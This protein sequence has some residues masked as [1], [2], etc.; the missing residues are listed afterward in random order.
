MSMHAL[1]RVSEIQLEGS[2]EA[3]EAILDESTGR[4]RCLCH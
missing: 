1:L 3:E 2:P 4:L